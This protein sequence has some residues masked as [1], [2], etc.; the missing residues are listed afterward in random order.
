M[1]KI[2]VRLNGEPDEIEEGLNVG[3][4]LARLGVPVAVAIVERNGEV[5]PKSRFGEEIVGAGDRIEIVRFMGG[6]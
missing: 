2:E 3:E 4:L 1:R 5:V 6:G